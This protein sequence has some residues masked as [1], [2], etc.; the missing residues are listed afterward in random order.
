MF[1]DYGM[2]SYIDGYGMDGVIRTPLDLQGV[3]LRNGERSQS[4]YSLWYPFGREYNYYGYSYYSQTTFKASGSA[5]IK[6]H[7][8]SFGNLHYKDR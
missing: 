8:F 5:D 3:G 2:T 1:R 4:L 6:D 7:E